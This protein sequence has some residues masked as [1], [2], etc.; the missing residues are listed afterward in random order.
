VLKTRVI[1]TLLYK[2]FGLVKGIGFDSRRA[3]GSPMQAVKVYEMRGVDELVFLDVTAT[4]QDRPP[5]FALVDDLAD[6]CFMPLTVGGGV[7][8]ADDVGHL[9]RVGADKVCVGTAAIEQPHLVADAARNFGS[10][11]IVVAV[12]TRTDGDGRTRV[13]ARS[14]SVPTDRSPVEMA[15][16]LE[17]SGAGEILL[18]SIDR[19]GTMKGYDLDT[20]REVTEAVTLPVIASGGAGSYDDMLAAVRAGASAVAAASMFHFTEQTPRGAKDHLRGNGVPV[21]GSST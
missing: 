9:L 11:C 4:H 16:E 19:D 2:D 17:R 8:T 5:D 21:R 3:V 1:P 18:Q 15:V 13:W 12:D 7:R 20:I 6:D 10:Q 14:G